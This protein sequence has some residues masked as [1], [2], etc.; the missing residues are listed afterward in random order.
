MAAVGPSQ[1][2]CFRVGFFGF[3][4]SFFSPAAVAP[5]SWAWPHHLELRVEEG[6]GV[7]CERWSIEPN[8][9]I[10]AITEQKKTDSIPLVED[11]EVVTI[12]KLSEVMTAVSKSRGR[13]CRAAQKHIKPRARRQ[14]SMV[15]D[16]CIAYMRQRIKHH[17]HSPIPPFVQL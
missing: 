6:S 16:A 17:T 1:A 15:D 3:S 14:N 7:V 2:P 13:I 4:F 9:G 5:P 8:E 11:E 12:L 10:T